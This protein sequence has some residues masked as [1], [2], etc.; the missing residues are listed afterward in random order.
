MR[1]ITIPDLHGK[2]VW[3]QV[4]PTAYDHLVFLGDY[5]DDRNGVFSDRH[6]LENLRGIIQLKLEFPEKII[7]LLGNHDVHYRDYPH[8]RSSGFRPG[9]RKPLQRLFRENDGSFQVAF[10]IENY[11]FTHAGVSAAWW[12][13]TKQRC[14][15]L[16][17]SAGQPMADRLNALLRSPESHCLHTISYLRGGDD[18]L[19]GPTWAD[20]DETHDDPLP[21][22]H[23]VVGHT[24][25]PRIRTFGD[26]TKSITYTDVLRTETR[27]WER[28]FS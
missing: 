9:L 3:R 14:P 10:Q 26:A 25:Q 19:G 24:P 21:D 6:M 27:F 28:N 8:F 13:W 4:D 11:L 2:T 22:H 12:A 7:L 1:V 5:V 20:F 15:A 16:N 18:P 17:E 23:Q